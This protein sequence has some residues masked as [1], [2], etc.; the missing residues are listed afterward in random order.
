MITTTKAY[1]DLEAAGYITAV[2]GKGY[3]VSERSS[4][5]L[6]EK[7]LEQIENYFD[8][9]IIT[10]KK[11]GL[12]KKY[13]LQM[14]CGMIMLGFIGGAN[15]LLVSF[16]GKLES[17]EILEVLLLLFESIIV[18]AILFGV[19]KIRFHGKSNDLFHALSQIFSKHEVLSSLSLIGIGVIFLFLSTIL[20]IKMVQK[21]YSS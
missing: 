7:L 20:S 13:Q 12:Q 4:K 18:G 1:N 17:R 21:K 19:S 6:Y 11:A 15:L 2:Q 16:T 14:M 5:L 9:A 8:Q 10:A 3:F